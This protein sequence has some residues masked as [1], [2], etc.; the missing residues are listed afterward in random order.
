MG[1]F[2]ALGA[3][4]AINSFWQGLLPLTGMVHLG[5]LFL[6][7]FLVKLGAPMMVA[8]GLTTLRESEF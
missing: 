4:L 1:G 7:A 8:R 2:F 3:L 6:L 5:G